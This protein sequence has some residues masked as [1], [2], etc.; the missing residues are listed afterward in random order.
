MAFEIRNYHEE[1]LAVFEMEITQTPAGPVWDIKKYE[2]TEDPDCASLW[3]DNEA[4][5]AMVFGDVT[6][7]LVA[8]NVGTSIPSR[9]GRLYSN[10]YPDDLL[11]LTMYLT[12]EFF[13]DTVE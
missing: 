3:A 10:K 9:W 7:Y 1:R 2:F 8:C 11:P 5:L 12:A 4:P 6:Y 13:D